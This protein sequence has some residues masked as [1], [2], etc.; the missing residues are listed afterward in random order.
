MCM[1]YRVCFDTTVWAMPETAIGLYPDVGAAYFLNQ[2]PPHL[3]GVGLYLGLTGTRLKA[4]D[5]VKTGE[6]R[7]SIEGTRSRGS[8]RG[9]DGSRAWS[10]SD[11]D[12]SFLPVLGVVEKCG[13]AILNTC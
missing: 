10:G 5:L 13:Y 12:R 2:L 7:G 6:G 1:K 4:A 11:L 8:R 3:E 9:S